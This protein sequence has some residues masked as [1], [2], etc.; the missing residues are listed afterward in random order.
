MKATQ[1]E[2]FNGDW[3]KPRLVIFCSFGAGSRSHTDESLGEDIKFV[4]HEAAEY[5]LLSVSKPS[6]N[7]WK[8][9]AECNAKLTFGTNFCLTL[10]RTFRRG[11]GTQRTLEQDV[12]VAEAL[13]DEGRLTNAR[14]LRASAE[15]LEDAKTPRRMLSESIVTIEVERLLNSCFD[16]Q[17]RA[18]DRVSDKNPAN[19][20]AGS[21]DLMRQ[22]IDPSGL[23]RMVQVRTSALILDANSDLRMA[24]KLWSEGCPPDTYK[25]HV[26]ENRAMVI[27]LTTDIK[28]RIQMV[29]DDDPFTFLRGLFLEDQGDRQRFFEDYLKGCFRCKHALCGRRLINRGTTAVELSDQHLSDVVK[30][31]CDD[32]PLATSA[33]TEDLHAGLRTSVTT[34]IGKRKTPLQAWLPNIC[35]ECAIMLTG[36]F[37]EVQIVERRGL[38]G[39][40]ACKR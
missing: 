11:L 36:V 27:R 34:A 14:R 37:T 24:S 40:L 35:R 6:R 10:P 2:L 31:S 12:H 25:L 18:R 15:S 17:K 23:I 39:H 22:L 3:R 1:F 38:G 29:W 21:I 20:A 7:R 16:A 4:L 30:D 13:G 32:V 19:N 26:R 8:K 5:S 9:R 28:F 33:G